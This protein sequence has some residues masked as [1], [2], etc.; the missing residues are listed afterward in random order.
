LN[1]LPQV[2]PALDLA[3]MYAGQVTLNTR[4]RQQHFGSGMGLA[5][6]LMIYAT[7]EQTLQIQI[8]KT[9]IFQRFCVASM[10]GVEHIIG[11]SHFRMSA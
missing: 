4:Q 7:L 10:S 11:N 5:L 1:I 8:R 3:G 9:H 2:M 6:S